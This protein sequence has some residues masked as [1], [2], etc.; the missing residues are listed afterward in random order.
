MKK[1]V[2]QPMIIAIIVIVVILVGVFGYYQLRTPTPN[3]TPEETKAAGN[4]QM[5]AMKA[6][7]QQLRSGTKPGGQ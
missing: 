1:E 4:R 7:M 3:V 2:S 6:A 5:D